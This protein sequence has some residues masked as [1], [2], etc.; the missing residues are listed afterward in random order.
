MAR[1]TR[2]SATQWLSRSCAGSA[3]ASQPLMPSFVIVPATGGSDEPPGIHAD[4]DT[5]LPIATRSRSPSCPCLPRSGAVHLAFNSVAQRQVL[6]MEGCGEI[7]KAI[8]CGSP[9]PAL[10]AGPNGQRSRRFF[11]GL[12]AT[13][14]LYRRPSA[15]CFHR[16]PSLPY[17]PCSP[18][19]TRFSAYPAPCGTARLCFFGFQKI[20]S[21]TSRNERGK[22]RFPEPSEN[23]SLG[24]GSGAPRVMSVPRAFRAN[25]NRRKTME[26]YTNDVKLTGYIGKNAESFATKNQ[27]T[28]VRFSLAVKSGYK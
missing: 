22:K 14:S 18:S 19:V 11:G 16:A 26:L 7:C 21:T 4:T 28:L 25:T 23:A 1:V 8:R 17:F 15:G 24:L 10:I 6:R 2:L 12:V 9:T 13:A 27:T 20:F 3:S 5:H